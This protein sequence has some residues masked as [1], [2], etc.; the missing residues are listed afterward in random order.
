M[1]DWIHQ[2]YVSPDPDIQRLFEDSLT[3]FLNIT[4][5]FPIEEICRLTGFDQNVIDGILIANFG[6]TRESIR[7][8]NSDRWTLM[9]PTLAP[10]LHKYLSVKYT[11][12]FDMLLTINN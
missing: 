5:W 10:I 1:N 12:T 2:E 4:F 7:F 3:E 11:T 6:H 8:A 9:D